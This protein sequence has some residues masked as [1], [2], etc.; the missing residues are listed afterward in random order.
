MR[1]RHRRHAVLPYHAVAGVPGAVP[2][3][4]VAG[5]LRGIERRRPGTEI[6]SN[7]EEIKCPFDHFCRTFLTDSV[8]PS[9]A[10]QIC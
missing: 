7:Q 5:A 8:P 2:V 1:R 4:A 3:S 10:P 9:P 6:K